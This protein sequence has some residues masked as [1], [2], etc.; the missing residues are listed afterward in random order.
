MPN[1]SRV[2]NPNTFKREQ[3]YL[4]NVA[5]EKSKIACRNKQCK[6]FGGMEKKGP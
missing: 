2:E 3:R 6:L 1:I 5:F 4:P